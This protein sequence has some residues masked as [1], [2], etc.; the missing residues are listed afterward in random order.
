MFPADCSALLFPDD[1]LADSLPDDCSVVPSRADSAVGMDD[2]AELDS[3][4]RAAR[5]E[6]ADYPADS[7]AGLRALQ[8]DP[9][10]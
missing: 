9:A 8:V 10:A 1:Y 3:P 7:S 4:Q 2:L 6:Q 5:L